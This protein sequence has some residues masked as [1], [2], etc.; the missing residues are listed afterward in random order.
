[1]QSSNG[2]EADDD[3]DGDSKRGK[4]KKKM[5][6]LNPTL[7]GFQCNAAPELVNRAGEIESVAN[8]PVKSGKK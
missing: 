8:A 3:I 1:M 5:Q 6:K 4:R 7:L 2:L